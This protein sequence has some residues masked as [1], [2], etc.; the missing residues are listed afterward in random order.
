MDGVFKEIESNREKVDGV[1]TDT[2]NEL[3]KLLQVKSKEIAS[4]ELR[5]E[6]NEN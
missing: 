5:M 2:F 3:S 6:K 4:L 1:I